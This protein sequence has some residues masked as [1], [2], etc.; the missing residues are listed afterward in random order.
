M[1]PGPMTSEQPVALV[2]GGTKGIGRA[3]SLELARSSRT[4]ANYAHDDVAATALETD[5]ASRATPVETIACDI[6]SKDGVDDLVDRVLKQAGRLDVVVFCAVDA[7][8][9]SAVDATEERWW[10]AMRTNAAPFLW[11]GQRLAQTTAGPGRLIGLTSP[12]SRRY[13]E[14]YAAIG[15]SKA[16]LESLVVYLA[17]ELAPRGITVNA[18]SGGL[19]DTELLR[20][21]VPE[22]AL[23][24]W[25][26]RTPVARLGEATDIVSLVAWLAGDGSEWMTG[27]VLTMDGGYFLR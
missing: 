8:L 19:V 26:R 17:V 12:F 21:R 20:S 15:P 23:D 14:G 22:K 11:L 3:V 7:Y 9:V 24:A 6:S 2:V 18:V 10:Q 25:A 5:A 27:Q 16:A 13:V 1:T 4:F